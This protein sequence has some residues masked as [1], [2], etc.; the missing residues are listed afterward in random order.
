[1][2]YEKQT[3]QTG[4]TITAEKLNHIED[5]IEDNQNN[6]YVEEIKT[7]IYDGNITLEE[8]IDDNGKIH[9]HCSIEDLD[10][11][12]YNDNIEVIFDGISYTCN[13]FDYNRYGA[14]WSAELQDTDWSIYPFSI[15]AGENYLNIST[16]TGGTHS[17][18]IN[19]LSQELIFSSE[20]NEQL[21]KRFGVKELDIIPISHGD[22]EFAGGTSEELKTYVY[23]DYINGYI[24]EQLCRELL[25][26][27]I[28]KEDINIT[29]GSR[30]YT[31]SNY[32]DDP[33]QIEA[34]FEGEAP[35]NKTRYLTLG[36]DYSNNY[37]IFVYYSEY[38]N[39]NNEYINIED[40]NSAFSI[41]IKANSFTS[42]FIFG[43]LNVIEEPLESINK[44]PLITTVSNNGSRIEL[45]WNTI[46]N[47]MENNGPVFI[48]NKEVDSIKYS[49]ITEASKISDNNYIVVTE[50][51]VTYSTDYMT[52]YPTKSTNT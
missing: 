48:K 41:S 27:R 23:K 8:W 20:L 19:K 17:I 3:W 26:H 14:N 47:Y 16:Q 1:M 28:K 9:Y 39:K 5:G 21:D 45:Y 30:N 11:S 4:D 12:I 34:Y 22:V 43:L 36:I 15:D 33:Y 44:I 7:V 6:Y 29:F 32:T 31:V 46:F 52:G 24:I 51:G 40:F 2:A 35:Y 37:N 18:K 49:L 38:D 25:S 42:P 13:S 10:K 50:D